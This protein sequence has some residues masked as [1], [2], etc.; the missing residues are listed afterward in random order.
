MMCASPLPSILAN[1]ALIKHKLTLNW[2][3][4][5]L[6]ESTL[7]IMFSN[8]R[9]LFLSPTPSFQLCR[10]DELLLQRP[11]KSWVHAPAFKPCRGLYAMLPEFCMKACSDP[12]FPPPFNQ[13][14]N[15]TTLNILHALVT[16]AMLSRRRGLL[17]GGALYSC[18]KAGRR[19]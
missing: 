12:S 13:Q 14:I 4:Q 8:W 5:V 11:R 10:A 1:N 18:Y 6:G 19:E 3:T 2:Y 16:E 7:N 15:S 9:L 17:Q